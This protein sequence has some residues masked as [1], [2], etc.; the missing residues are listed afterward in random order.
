MPFKSG[1]VA[2]IGRPN[3]GKSTL[4][5]KLVGQK[6][7][8]VSNKPQ[9]TRNRVQGIVNRDD[10][11]IVLIDTPGIH[12]PENVLSRMMMDELQH[13]LEGLDI[14]C[15][16]VDA[17]AKFGKGDEFALD[18]IKR[19]K[20]P[21]YLLLNKID[22]VAKH[23]LLPMIARYN[24]EFQFA[25]TFPISAIDGRGLDDL[26]ASWIARLPEGPKYFPDDQ[27]TDQPERFLAAEV[28]REKAILATRQEVPHAIAVLVDKYEEKPKLLRISATIYVEREGQ[29]GILIG[30]GGGTLKQIGTDARKELEKLLGS[31]IFMELFV[32]VQANWRQNSQM[33]KMLDWHRQLEELQ[34][35]QSPEDDDDDPEREDELEEA[36]DDED[37]K[38]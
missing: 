8:I 14:L 10:A 19:F 23:L 24:E 30:A 18:W 35:R 5:N 15:L 22:M 27:V 1:F 29:K 20:G 21:A 34:E 4:V 31:K 17:S 3:A 25:E 28:I 13:T 38:P 36:E 9:T 6:V 26:V 37:D 32:K 11:Q 12:R 2:I 33:V 16:I 7:S